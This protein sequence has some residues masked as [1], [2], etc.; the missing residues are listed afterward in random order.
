[1]K[2]P[3][4]QHSAKLEEELSV[5]VE[6]IAEVG[7][8]QFHQGE[9]PLQY[10]W[11]VARLRGGAP[12]LIE[13]DRFDDLRYFTW[14][15]VDALTDASPSVCCLRD[16]RAESVLD[17]LPGFSSTRFRPLGT[18][19]SPRGAGSVYPWWGVHVLETLPTLDSLQSAIEANV[20]CD[21]VYM[22]PPCQAYR[23]FGDRVDVAG[24]VRDSLARTDSINLYVHVPFCRQILRVLQPIHGPDVARRCSQALRRRAR[25]AR[26]ALRRPWWSGRGFG[27]CTSGAERP[28]FFGQRFSNGFSRR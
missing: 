23:P 9:L 15:E 17:V 7:T 24:M 28:R 13:R 8:E 19:R 5:T 16:R 2:T 11:Y 21:Y 10:T 12:S 22:Y 14:A 27:P 20:R 6:M 4:R 3:G 18:R 1:M 26:F 25:S